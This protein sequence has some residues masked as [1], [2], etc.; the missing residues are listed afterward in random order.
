VLAVVLGLTIWKHG[1]ELTAPADP[2]NEY[3]AARPEWYFL[4][5]FQMLKLP[6]FAG[7]NEVYGAIGV[8][9]LVF[10]FLAL[11]PVLGKWKLGH[12][13]N[14][15]FLVCLLIGAGILTFQAVRQDVLDVA[16]YQPAVKRG[17]ADAERAIE[18]AKQ[19]GIPPTG[20][21]GLLRNDPLTQ[22]SKL[23]AANCASCHSFDSGRQGPYDVVAKESSAPNLHGFATQQWIEGLLDPV[24]YNSPAYFGKTAHT[25]G[26]MLGYLQGDGAAL[27]ADDKKAIAAALAAEAGK[28]AKDAVL[29]AKGKEIMQKTCVNCHR[30]HDAGELGTAPD[31]TAY[32]SRDWLI[33]FIS[34]PT[35]ARFYPETNDRMPSFG[36]SN[37]LERDRIEMIVD[38]IR[39]SQGE[40]EN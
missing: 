27:T 21:V 38:W 18:L 2:A 34:D 36:K 26:E 15:G 37:Q 20:A 5:L 10:F 29:I 11:M 14:V 31:L 4:S 35:H 19:Y 28:T 13:F 7:E 33:D 32:G 16:Q 30:F 23:F 22:G 25:T 40:L 3:S 39:I 24:K 6:A 9:G 1:A 8:P 12:F 17:N